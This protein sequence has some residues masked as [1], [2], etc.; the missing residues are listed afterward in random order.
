MRWGQTRE[1]KGLKTV[2]FKTGWGYDINNVVH[3]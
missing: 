3:P 1:K 2:Y